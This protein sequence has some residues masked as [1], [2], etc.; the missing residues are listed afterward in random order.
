MAAQTSVG[1]QLVWSDEF[2]GKAGSPPDPAKWNFDIGRGNPPGWGN[3]ELET[4][5]NLP[6]NA[7]QD[8]NGNLIIRAIRESNGSYT[9]ARLQTGA[10]GASTQTTDGHWQ[11]GR[12]LARI[13]LPYLK[14]TWP[15]FW[16]LG[17]N[18]GTAGWPAC[19]EIDIMENFGG[20]KNNAGLNTGTAHGP[21]YSGGQGISKP[22]TLP[23]GEK[24]AD[25]FHVYAIEW[26]QDSIQWSVDGIVYHKATPASLPAGARWV[27]NAPF[28]IL[29]NVAVGGNAAGSPDANASFPPQDML[30]DYVRVY[31]PVPVAAASPVILPGAVFNAASSLSA[32]AP[33]SLATLYGSNLADAEH[34]V[35]ANPD[36]PSSVAGVSVSVNGS[37]APLTYVSPD[38][39]NFQLPWDIPVGPADI[40]ATRDGAAGNAENVTVT[41]AAPSAFLNDPASGLVWVNGAGCEARECA[42]QAGS[43]YWLWGNGFGTSAPLDPSGC[44]LTIGG[45]PAVVQYCGGAPGEIIN[46]LNF[47]YPAVVNGTA[48]YADATLTIAGVTG[49]FRVPAPR[50]GQQ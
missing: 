8:G 21:G 15:A 35:N 7:F 27:F 38:Q 9:S 32:L 23:Y 48:P 12:I 20:N 47:V 26:S 25:D 37:P 5:T 19:G 10:P 16:T 1:W 18:I 29:L 46:Q 33:G 30:V 31:Q 6:Q 28:F 45:Q 13:K 42:V 17:E 50:A 40:Q 34:L 36:F 43:V 11:Y 24:V 2:N 22:Y 4:Y 44:S 41:A 49:R 39:I 14:G 3:N